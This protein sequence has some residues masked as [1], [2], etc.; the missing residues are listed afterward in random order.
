MRV[1]WLGFLVACARAAGAGPDALCDGPHDRR[2]AARAEHRVPD[3]A[4]PRGGRARR[5]PRTERGRGYSRVR[6]AD[7]GT[8]GWILTR[9]LDGRADRARSTRG[10]RSGVS[11]PRGSASR[12]SRQQTA[13]LTRDLAATRTE[14]AAD[15]QA[16]HGNVSKELTDI[17]TAAANVV[18]IR[19]Q[20]TRLQQRLIER[21]REVE[22]LTADNAAPRRPQQSELVR[23]RRGA[24][25]SRES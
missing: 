11:P 9:F 2:A 22:E 21:E 25:C 17:K 10:R 19:D 15:S 6:V 16:N 13:E 23:R 20:N 24:C 5:G 7:Q 4:Q 12:R 8:E 14:L 3:P 18:E 1:R